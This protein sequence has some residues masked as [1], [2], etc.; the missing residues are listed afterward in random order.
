MRYRYSTLNPSQSESDSLPWLPM[1]L[2]NGHHRMD[3]LGLVDSGATVSV[4]PYDLGKQI[5]FNWDDRQA[6]IRL[7]GSLGS[8]PAI[9]VFAMSQIGDA[10]LTRLAFAWTQAPHAPLILGQMNFFMEFD[11]SFYRARLE[12]DVS[13]ASKQ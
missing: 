4:L 9:P 11:V 7:A 2:M 12:F 13:L 10:P 6:V 1:R 5:G 3:V 8:A